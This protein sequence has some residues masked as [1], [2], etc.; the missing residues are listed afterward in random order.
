MPIFENT[1]YPAPF[2]LPNGHAQTLYPTIFRSVHLPTCTVERI[3]TYDNDYLDIDFH[4]AVKPSKKMRV[5]IISHGAEGDSKK[6]YV[7]GMARAMTRAGWDVAAWNFRGCSGAPNRRL[8]TYHSGSVE[9]LHS[10]VTHC[11][12][13]GYTEVVLIGFSMGGNQILK[14]LGEMSCFVPSAVQA[15]VV[16]S[17][18]CDIQGSSDALSKSI[19]KMYVMNIMRTVR[20]KVQ[21]KQEQFADVFDARKL[22]KAKNFKEFD[23]VFTAPF[24][25]FDNAETLWKHCSCLQYLDG[26]R[27]PTLLLNARNDPFLSPT[28]YPTGQAHRSKYLYLETPADGGHIGFVRLADDEY[29]WSEIRAVEFLGQVLR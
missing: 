23:D 8:H 14:Y 25:G 17:V 18:P 4:D 6:A 3:A 20:G 7:K 21:Q 22:L 5:A 2:F 13:K 26:I 19:N 16:F 27:V 15:A 28:C 24:Y 12:G 29:Y 9:D 11:C 1:L 10:V